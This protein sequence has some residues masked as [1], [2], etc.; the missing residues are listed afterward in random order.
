MKIRII[1]DIHGKIDQYSNLLLSCKDSIDGSIQIG[2]FGF[3]D[4]YDTRNAIFEDFGIDKSSHLF[5]PGNHDDYDSLPDFN[6]GDF[7]ET[8]FDPN[9]FF[10]RGAL[11]ID[12]RN[13]T[14]HVDW[15]REEELNVMQ[16]KE[17]QRL[18]QESKPRIV[19]THDGPDT[20][21]RNL[22]PG[23]NRYVTQTGRFL[24]QLFQDHKPDVWVFG[25]WHRNKDMV[26]GG[27]RFICLEELAHL[28]IEYYYDH[29]DSDNDSSTDFTIQI[30]T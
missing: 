19:L 29:H 12:K 28:D 2:D 21:C 30:N 4:D 18:Y 1:S 27:T 11:S 5:F 7:G 25:H 6:M 8:P 17:C 23:M 10:I 15:W 24:D 16:M 20:A 9:T 14:E 26:V 3:S 22:F 13:R